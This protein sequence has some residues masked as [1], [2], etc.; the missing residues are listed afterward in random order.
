MPSKPA[1]LLSAAL[2]LFSS[3]TARAHFKLEKPVDALKTDESGNPTGG[4][5]KTS[6]CGTGATPS[7]LATKVRAGSKLHIKIVETVAHGGHYRIALSPNRKDFVDPK[8]VVT[9]GSCVSAAVE[10]SP[11]GPVLA[12]G[13]F[14]H[15]QGIN[16]KV[17]ETDVTLPN[18]TCADC[19][20]QVI[21]FMTPHP[22][23]CFYYH[24]ANLQI[25]DAN[26]EIEGDGVVSVG[27]GDKS[28]GDGGTNGSSGSSGARGP[29]G[30]SGSSGSSGSAA[31][32]SSSGDK[33]SSQAPSEDG[34]NVGGSSSPSLITLGVFGA[35]VALSKRRRRR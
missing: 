3:S 5:Q 4:D 31:T 28:G 18:T 2:V 19:T 24:C 6:P 32:G 35:M 21:E 9:A 22:P 16:D 33:S 11:S 20:L 27:D 30:S 10:S 14:E 23:S 13:L 15:R 12:D 7:G 25:V 26:A 8:V 17:W 1:V 29:N 34:C